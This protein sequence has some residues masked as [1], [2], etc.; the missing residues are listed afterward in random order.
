[1]LN[2]NHWLALKQMQGQDIP[3]VKERD[4]RISLTVGSPQS[5]ASHHTRL[6][7]ATVS[8]SRTGAFDHDLFHFSEVSLMFGGVQI[9]DVPHHANSDMVIPGNS[10]H[11]CQGESHWRS[12]TRASC[13]GYG[14]LEPLGLAS[15]P[16]VAARNIQQNICVF[17]WVLFLPNIGLMLDFVTT[18]KPAKERENTWG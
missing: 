11:T 10:W 7:D 8:T 17:F 18:T 15:C 4:K 13:R 1:M 6:S 12:V 16:T 3:G 9:F 5:W 2:E 14:R